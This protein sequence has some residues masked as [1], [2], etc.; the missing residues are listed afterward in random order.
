MSK[1]DIRVFSFATTSKDDLKVFIN[2]LDASKVE[3]TTDVELFTIC[4]TNRQDAKMYS[5]AQDMVWA[6]M[7]IKQLLRDEMKYWEQS[8][9]LD[10][11]TLEKIRSEINNIIH[12][13]GVSALLED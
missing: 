8:S 1:K 12:E 3:D 6:L 13:N 10:Y 7:E 2:E 9:K 5:H 11:P 4:T